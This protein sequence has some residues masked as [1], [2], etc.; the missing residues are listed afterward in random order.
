M[1]LDHQDFQWLGGLVG[2]KGGVFEIAEEFTHPQTGHLIRASRAWNYAPATQTAT[3][4]TAWQ[5]LAADGT[6]VDH[7]ETP[8][9]PLHCIFR[10]E[11]EHLLKRAGFEVEH[12]YGDFFRRPLED[13]SPGMVW[14]ARR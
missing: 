12:L 10:F 3:C 5:A 4:R 14:V 8:P 1:H 11:M 2:E 6:I 9:V 7:W 13:K